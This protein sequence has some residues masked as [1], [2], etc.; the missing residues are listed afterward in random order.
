MKKVLID[1]NVTEA[2]KKQFESISDQY[3]ITYDKEDKDVEIIVGDCPPAKCQNY[4]K[5]E[6]LLSTWVGYDGFI[7]KGILPENCILCNAVDAHTEEVAEHMFAMLLSMEKKLHTYRDNQASAK[8]HDESTVKSIRD[9]T[10]VVLGLGNIGK[11]LAN[12]CKDLGMYV[13][14]VKRD[15]TDKPSYVDELYSLDKLD[16]ILPRVD[17]VLNVLPSTPATKHLFS[18]DKFKLMK[19]DALLI[20]GGRGDLIDTDVLIEVLEKKVIRGV[21]QDV[22]EKEPIPKDSKL[23][24]LDNLLITPHVAGFFHLDKDR[25]KWV[26]ICCDNLRRYINNEELNNVVTEREK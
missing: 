2:Q 21:G 7:K 24:K 1:N 11:Y 20:N 5:L 9:L 13:I 16:E 18:M 22:F 19:R 8:W 17:A 23:W 4:P 25:Q 3:I 14:G 6:L 10:V 26:D 12:L 15:L